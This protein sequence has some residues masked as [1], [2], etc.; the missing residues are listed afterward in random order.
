[1]SQ[2]VR[3]LSAAGGEER[4]DGDGPEERPGEAGGGE[5]RE[6]RRRQAQLLQLHR[7]LQNVEVILLDSSS[8][9]CIGN[10]GG[11]C[12][13]RI[14]FI[15]VSQVRGKVGIFE[16]HISGIRAQVLNSELQRS[17]HSPRRS[18]VQT[19]TGTGPESPMI[20]PQE[21]RVPPVV[22]NGREAEEE[23]AQD[24]GIKERDKPDTENQTVGGQNGR[25]LET[26]VEAP[27][28]N[29]LFVAQN[30]HKRI[31]ADAAT[32]KEDREKDRMEQKDE[33]E[34]TDGLLRGR[35]EAQSLQTEAIRP[36]P[37]N[38][39]HSPSAPLP[40]PSIPAVIITDLGPECQPGSEDPGSDQGLSST[41]SLS[42]S[43]NSSSRSLRK[44]SSSS[45]SSAGF[46][47]SW[48]E[49]EEDISSDTEKGEQLLN[50]AVLTSRQKAVSRKHGMFFPSRKPAQIGSHLTLKDI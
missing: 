29:R 36:N 39:N 31:N 19:P 30:S 34:E 25:H 6:E 16:A 27:S 24:G 42:S 22:Q 20:H 28:L 45:A 41:P 26:P 8:C 14:C 37:E 9:V 17:P 18:P 43:P 5:K 11:L 40:I 12:I 47:S 32:D 1:M 23:T 21:Y 48:E 13:C 38:T 3:R 33:P 44:L 7:E 46:S 35:R 50:P 15:P 2:R 4:G 10:T 49:S